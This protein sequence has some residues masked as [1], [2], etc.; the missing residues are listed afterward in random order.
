MTP[1]SLLITVVDVFHC[2]F[3]SFMYDVRKVR[4]MWLTGGLANMTI[5]CTIVSTPD[6]M[7][8]MYRAVIPNSTESRVT[9]ISM[10]YLSSNSRF[11]STIVILARPPVPIKT[12]FILSTAD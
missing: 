10:Y 7:K 3:T 9:C 6:E 11:L 8:N 2:T 12:Y 1:N 5:R 4:F